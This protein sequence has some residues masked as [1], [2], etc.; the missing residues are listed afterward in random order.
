MDKIIKERGRKALSF[1]NKQRMV[2]KMASAMHTVVFV[3]WAMEAKNAQVMSENQNY[4]G[5]L[6]RNVDE[7]SGQKSDKCP[8]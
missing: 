4:D 2:H 7:P 3:D 5:R 1:Q 6:E 8:K